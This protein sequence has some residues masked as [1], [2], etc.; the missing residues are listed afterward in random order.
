VFSQRGSN[1]YQSTWCS[2]AADWNLQHNVRDVLKIVLVPL[3]IFAFNQHGCG[4]LRLYYAD[5]LLDFVFIYCTLGLVPLSLR[6][7]TDENSSTLQL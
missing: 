1:V 4:F 2:I 5:V 3:N 7:F 6:P